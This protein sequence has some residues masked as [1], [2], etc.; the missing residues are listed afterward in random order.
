VPQ[1]FAFLYKGARPDQIYSECTILAV[2]L[3]SERS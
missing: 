3:L 1:P 2:R